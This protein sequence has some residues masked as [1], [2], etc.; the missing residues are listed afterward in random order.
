MN[1]DGDTSDA[2]LCNDNLTE[3]Y[4]FCHLKWKEECI[5][6]EKQKEKINILVQDKAHLTT[7]NSELKV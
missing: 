6:S 3:A 5:S 2:Y 7:I 4:K 1:I